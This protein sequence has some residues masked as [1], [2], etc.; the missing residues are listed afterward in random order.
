MNPLSTSK[1][2]LF[3]PTLLRYGVGIVLTVSVFGVSA[4]TSSDTP[5]TTPVQAEANNQT[6][7]QDEKPMTRTEIYALFEREAK[8]A[9]AIAKKGCQPLSGQEQQ[10]C[11]AQAR[12]QYDA[13]LRYAKKRADQGY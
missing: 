4:Q 13:D 8:A 3:I 11:L 12:L 1:I 7:D 2:S 9:Y 5:D 10:R 6:N